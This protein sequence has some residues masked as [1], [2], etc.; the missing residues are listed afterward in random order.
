MQIISRSM[1]RDFHQEA[2]EIANLV[3]INDAHQ[4]FVEIAES[5][6]EVARLLDSAGKNNDV[7]YIDRAADILVDLSNKEYSLRF[8]GYTDSTAMFKSNWSGMY[9]YSCIYNYIR[10]P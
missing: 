8:A 1:Y 5:W 2:Y 6:T 9:N 3:T 10:V 7:W 4:K